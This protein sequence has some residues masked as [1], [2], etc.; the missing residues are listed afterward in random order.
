M[1]L[2]G[3]LDT[4]QKGVLQALIA[5]GRREKATDMEILSAVCTGLVEQTLHNLPGGD[6]TSQGWRQEIEGKGSVQQRLTLSYSIPHYYAECR[7]FRS[8]AS[9]AGELAALVQRPA[10][11]YRGRYTEHEAEARQLLQEAPSGG[12]F[13]FGPSPTNPTKLVNSGPTTIVQQ[14]DPKD[15]SPR[16][17]HTGKRMSEYGNNYAGH[18]AALRSLLKRTVKL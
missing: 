14:A 15:S 11:Q 8:Q 10:A 9:T 2:Y 6:G 12:N 13:T 1:S 5:Y 4:E 3:E 18:T 7:E 17:K 16:I